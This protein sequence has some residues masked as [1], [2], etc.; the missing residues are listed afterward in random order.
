M[1]K[2]HEF[3]THVRN[4]HLLWMPSREALAALGD[5]AKLFENADGDLL[6]A[7]SGAFGDSKLVAAFEA[8]GEHV[9][10][11]AFD[12]PCSV[13]IAEAGVG[14]WC[15][16]PARGVG[17]AVSRDVAEVVC[18]ASF[19]KLAQHIHSCQLLK[20]PTRASLKAL[21]DA[22]RRFANNG[23]EPDGDAWLAPVS[24]FSEAELVAARHV[25][26]EVVNGYMF[27]YPCSVEFNPRVR[28]IKPGEVN[29]HGWCGYSS[30]GV[31]Y[32]LSRDV[33]VIVCAASML[34]AQD[35]NENK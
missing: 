16:Y 7:A 35:D 19:A 29:A 5:R 18:A 22:A 11:Y 17:Y 12:Y 9:W 31:G 13:S 34:A 14:E 4:F 3:S 33:A 24:A 6:L 32:A 23:G 21:G 10:G 15:A 26:G 25:G 27:D 20:M 2:E 30:R 1:K 28:G 8:G